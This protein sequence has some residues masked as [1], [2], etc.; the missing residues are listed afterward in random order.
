MST[1]NVYFTQPAAIQSLQNQVGTDTYFDTTGT[2]AGL[3]QYGVTNPGTSG[4]GAFLNAVVGPG[5][6][7][8][9]QDAK[10][11]GALGWAVLV[12]NA[13]T[14]EQVFF[15]TGICNSGSAPITQDT[16]LNLASA[17]KFVNSFTWLKALEE[18]LI[19]TT[20]PINLYVPQCD[21]I[22]YAYASDATGALTT[23]ATGIPQW[24][25]FTGSLNTGAL[26]EI[27]VGHCISLNIGFPNNPCFSPGGVGNLFQAAAGATP[28]YGFL[29]SARDIYNAQGLGI[30]YAVAGSGPQQAEAD[31]N[32]LWNDFVAAYVP[33]VLSISGASTAVY[34]TGANYDQV[35]SQLKCIKSQAIRLAWKV[36]ATAISPLSNI[37]QQKSCYASLNYG[38]LGAA[39][40]VAT[41][42]AGYA[43][44]FAYCKAKILDPLSISTSDI[45]IQNFNAPVAPVGA[46]IADVCGRR[47]QFMCTGAVTGAIGVGAWNNIG[48]DPNAIALNTS[49][50]VPFNSL[51]FNSQMPQD[52][53][54][55]AIS[56]LLNRYYTTD[57][58]GWNM[59]ISVVSNIKSWAKIIQLFINQ[60]VY[61]NQQVLSRS[62]INWS[63][64]NCGTPG[65][66]YE[67]YSGILN[68]YSP[69]TRWVAAQCVNYMTGD[70]ISD[71]QFTAASLPGNALGVTNIPL[72][73]S[74][75]CYYWAGA[76]GCGWMCDTSNGFYILQ[77]SG[78]SSL[79]NNSRG[80]NTTIPYQYVKQAL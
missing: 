60:G 8:I 17:A 64:N 6:T 7:T 51:Y 29:C 74:S 36:G 1:Q 39:T 73:I 27:T 5:T 28:D 15:S 44:L 72:S 13:F 16:M 58:Y 70:D 32:A 66:F 54:L 68:S 67:Q 40:A 42:R 19:R 9:A 48:V 41:A 55:F 79:T 61:N 52:K 31:P 21:G 56:A 26:S 53:V 4:T 46:V 18:R 34:Q 37:K 20:D 24:D 59:G 69:N 10:G 14:N 33:N 78:V 75:S 77:Y 11:T 76:C 2:A 50:V 12:G 45:F 22:Y 57:P 38:L 35:L 63:K 71:I 65:S 62:I 80:V 23:S 25:S 43:N 30:Q 3:L 49:G 47:P